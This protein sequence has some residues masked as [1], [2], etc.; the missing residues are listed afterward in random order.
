MMMQNAS[1]SLWGPCPLSGTPF[2]SDSTAGAVSTRA[3]GRPTAAATLGGPG[4]TLLCAIL[5][6]SLVVSMDMG[7]C[8]DRAP[9][10]PAVAVMETEWKSMVEAFSR[11][12]DP[13]KEGR[14]ETSVPLSSTT[15]SMV[16]GDLEFVVLVLEGGGP[17]LKFY[18]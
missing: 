17:V 9:P 2:P 14:V 8:S 5:A 18:I 11:P 10:G 13:R 12:E 3:G 6:T 1:C 15:G 7:R 4:A 16:T